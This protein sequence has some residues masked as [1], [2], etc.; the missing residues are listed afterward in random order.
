MKKDNW[1]L[2]LLKQRRVWGAFLSALAVL[3]Y[4]LGYPVVPQVCTALAGGLGLHS[5]VKPKK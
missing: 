1:F 2:V 5:Y 3:G 4:S